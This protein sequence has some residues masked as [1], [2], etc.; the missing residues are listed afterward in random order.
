MVAGECAKTRGR[1]SN[2]FCEGEIAQSFLGL[3]AL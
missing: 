3:S 1:Q 2:P